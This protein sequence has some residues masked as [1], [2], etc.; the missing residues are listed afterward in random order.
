MKIRP[1][2][3][4]TI[5][6]IYYNQYFILKK[7]ICKVSSPAL[8]CNLPK[9]PPFLGHTPTA[10]VILQTHTL[11]HTQHTQKYTLPHL[12]AHTCKHTVTNVCTQ[13]HTHLCTCTPMRT[14][15]D[16]S[17]T[18]TSGFCPVL[19]CVRPPS[20]SSLPIL[21]CQALLTKDLCFLPP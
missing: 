7:Y 13:I 10:R 20:S 2:Y 19:R 11:P 3:L 5:I 1:N 16:A 6:D 14:H 4:C 21:S 12:R 18:P 17:P 15:A 9:S 8:K